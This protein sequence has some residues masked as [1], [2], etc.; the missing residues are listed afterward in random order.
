[1]MKEQTKAESS[2]PKQ[3]EKQEETQETEGDEAAA[4]EKSEDNTK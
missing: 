3:E 1:M 2:Q 4:P